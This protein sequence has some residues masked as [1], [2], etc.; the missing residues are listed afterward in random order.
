[1]NDLHLYYTESGDFSMVDRGYTGTRVFLG[2]GYV[3]ASSSHLLNE[4][5]RDLQLE[6]DPENIH[7]F[8]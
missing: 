6:M 3:D 4:T 1:M 2:L 5:Q 7:L 8:V